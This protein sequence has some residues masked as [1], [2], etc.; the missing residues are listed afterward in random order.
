MFS[1]IMS[2]LHFQKCDPDVFVDAVFIPMLKNVQ[3]SSLKHDLT[4][5][6]PTLSVW[7][8]YLFATCR[9]LERLKYFNVL[10]EMQLFMEVKLVLFY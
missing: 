8:N 1:I 3:L 2:I 4:N 6:D 7:W 5:N 9:Q 10:Y